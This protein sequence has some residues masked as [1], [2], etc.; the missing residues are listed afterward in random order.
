MAPTK[1]AM[2]FAVELL[3][4]YPG[5]SV[6]E[7]SVKAIASALDAV[8]LE[9]ADDVCSL[10]RLRSADPP[11]VAQVFQVGREIA[12]D[13]PFSS[14]FDTFRCIFSDERD[15]PQCGVRHGH[16]LTSDAMLHCLY[17]LKAL[18]AVSPSKRTEAMRDAAEH[19]EK[20]SCPKRASSR[21]ALAIAREVMP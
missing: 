6:A 14:D 3:A 1:H 11:S 7:A 5:R 20:C 18:L 4:A 9:R 19:P 10:L 13:L 15:C 12:G 2:A 16:L 21:D 17:H 8:G